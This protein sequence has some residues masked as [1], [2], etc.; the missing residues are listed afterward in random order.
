MKSKFLKGNERGF[1]LVE[2]LIVIAIIG[3]LMGLALAG[4]RFAQQRARDLQRENAVRNISTALESYYVDNQKYPAGSTS[5]NQL[6][7]TTLSEY[8]E[9]SFEL[10]GGVKYT[11]FGYITGTNALSYSVCIWREN[12]AKT[13]PKD[14]IVKGNDTNLNTSCGTEA[15]SSTG[16][17]PQVDPMF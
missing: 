2:L 14:L 3:V 15:G 12:S 7:T 1:T 4:M 5:I 11:D 13:D 10:P 6:V 9:D 16:S 17:G 8:L